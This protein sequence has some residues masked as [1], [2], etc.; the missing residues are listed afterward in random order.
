MFAFVLGAV[1]GAVFNVLCHFPVPFVRTKKRKAKHC[2]ATTPEAWGAPAAKMFKSGHDN[3]SKVLCVPQMRCDD[4]VER[5]DNAPSSCS[6]EDD[7]LVS[8]SAAEEPA[9]IE[10]KDNVQY[11]HMDGSV[12][13]SNW[14]GE[15]KYNIMNDAKYD[16]SP[17]LC[18]RNFGYPGTWRQL[19]LRITTVWFRD[20]E[21]AR[22]GM[23]ATDHLTDLE[24]CLATLYFLKHAS[25]SCDQLH[26]QKVWG[27]SK[28]RYTTHHHT[29]ITSIIT[30]QSLTHTGAKECWLCGARDGKR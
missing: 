10:W 15:C 5:W 21:S 29:H 4:A 19:I 14:S 18:K 27:I 9:R 22:S 2:M 6:N 3:E 23:C 11:Q 20:V 1:D 12:Q 17:G 25:R 24:Q 7:V 26:L 8:S 30:L 28:R 13:P 16:A